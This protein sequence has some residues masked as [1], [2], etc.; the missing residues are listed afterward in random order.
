MHW[1]RFVIATHAVI[2]CV[3]ATASELNVGPEEYLSAVRSLQPGHTLRLRAGVY[4]EGLPVRYLNGTQDEP[5]TITGPRTGAPAIFPARKEHNTVSIVNSSYVT[6]RNLMLDGQ[7]IPVDAIKAEGYSD[8]AHNITVDNLVI[9]GH[10]ANQQT[11]GISTKCPAWEW[12]L[13]RNVIIGAG[14]GMYLGN[15]DGTEPFFA[16][17]IEHNLV[18]DTLGYNLQI[19]HQD[20]R[21]LQ[22]KP[23]T[24]IRHNVFSKARNSS[25]LPDARPNVLVGHWPST[26]PGATDHYEIYGNL[27]YQNP[28]EALFQ[29]EG[30]VAI[31]N[32]IFINDYGDAVHIQPHNDIPKT[33]D[34]FFNTVLA[35]DQGIVI[36]TAGGDRSFEQTVSGNAVFANNPILGGSR[37]H[38]TVGNYSDAHQYLIQPIGSIGD[39]NLLPR[40]DRVRGQPLDIKNISRYDNWNRDFDGNYRDLR[41]RGAYGTSESAPSWQLQ[42]ELKPMH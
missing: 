19:K 11:V 9:T 35:L 20:G 40:P 21:I 39:L 31:Y 4:T 33:I 15:S 42:L 24:V 41:T 37:L 23:V 28:N 26:G 10:G 2:L 29:G 16:G 30:N 36:R 13:R 8:W 34:I 18:I 14:T 6:I 7:G 32:N 5:I 1:T 38:N 22:E 25:L 27:F 3:T 17:L 12:I